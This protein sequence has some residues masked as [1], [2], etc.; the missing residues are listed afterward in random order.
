M[1]NEFK[2]TARRRLVEVRRVS[3]GT[4]QV[5]TTFPLETEAKAGI[6]VKMYGF[7]FAAYPLSNGIVGVFCCVTDNSQ[8]NCRVVKVLAVVCQ[9]PQI[10]LKQE[11]ILGQPL[12]RFEHEMLELQ[13]P[14]NVA[15]FKVLYEFGEFRVLLAAFIKV[16]VDCGEFPDV[17]SVEL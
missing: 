13:I 8:C 4:R 10:I 16:V 12:H 6:A 15:F 17:G 2:R 7:F 1:E 5:F 11:F 14:A 3:W 9:M